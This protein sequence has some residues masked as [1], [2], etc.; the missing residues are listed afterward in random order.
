[1]HLPDSDKLQERVERLIAQ[2]VLKEMDAKELLKDN[3]AAEP[4]RK[5]RL[6]FTFFPPKLASEHGIGRFFR[7]WGGEALYNSHESNAVTGQVLQGIGTPCIIEAL[8]PIDGFQDY[9]LPIRFTKEYMRYAKITNDRLDEYE[10]DLK[11]PLNPENIAAIHLFP[12]ARFSELSGC[13]NW[14]QPLS[15]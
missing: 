1:M 15:L 3:E 10:G 14:R 11:V 7:S 13:D 6:W 2:N 12:G 4:S 5:D 9:S 8:L